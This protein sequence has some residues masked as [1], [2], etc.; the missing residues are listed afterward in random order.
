M[1]MFRIILNKDSDNSWLTIY[2]LAA[3][4]ENFQFLDCAEHFGL[5]LALTGDACGDSERLMATLNTHNDGRVTMLEFMNWTCSNTQSV[6]TATTHM[7]AEMDLDDMLGE[8]NLHMI[9][10]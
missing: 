4:L 7:S 3:A 10:M 9:N 5:N 6:A 2:E 8:M 1:D